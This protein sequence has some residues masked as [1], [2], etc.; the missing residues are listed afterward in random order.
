[1]IFLLLAG[2]TWV[3][4][5]DIKDQL[6]QVDDDGDGFA[7]GVDCND[8]S[9]AVNP[10]APET[11][12][13]GVDQDCAGDDDFDQD[14]DGAAMEVDC[15]DE[16]AAVN[17]G[18]EEV[19]YDGVD[20]DCAGGDEIDVDA[21]GVPYTEDCDDTDPDSYPGAPEVWYDGTDQDC[22]GDADDDQDGDG[23]PFGTDCDD[24]D[25]AV[26]PGAP[27]AWYDG[28]DSDCGGDN[29]YDQDVDGHDALSG[30]G[31]DCDDTDAAV[32]PD[33]LEGIG[34]AVDSDCDGTDDGFRLRALPGR[35]WTGA[36]A[37]VLVAD[38]AEVTLSVVATVVDSG[39]EILYDSAPLFSLVP[40]DAN[41]S[42]SELEGWI[43]NSSDPGA[44]D[45][46]Q[47]SGYQ[48]DGGDSY[49]VLPLDTV[50]GRSLLLAWFDPDAGTRS[51]VT[52]A[53]SLGTSPFDDVSLYLDDG[54]GTHAALGCDATEGVIAWAR[55][56]DPRA[57]TPAA[58]IELGG[59][60]AA[61]CSFDD[62]GQLWAAVGGVLTRIDL[63]EDTDG[64]Y[65]TAV[66]VLD[67]VHAIDLDPAPGGLAGVDGD[68]GA[69][70][71]FDG[72]IATEVPSTVSFSRVDVLPDFS[73][74]VGIGTD[75]GPRWV[76]PDGR[77]T[78]L[79]AP[80]SASDGA[81]VEAAGFRVVV[82][83]GVDGVA[84]GYARLP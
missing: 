40:S 2:C 25:A 30:A 51:T 36:S 8:Q 65:G 22:G 79:T 75:G 45:V 61:A 46:G 33:A 55:L 41:L 5:S 23:S 42:F 59:N 49:G 43:S 16:V 62:G 19:P 70:F 71:V 13:D 15:D 28:V 4:Q 53:G 26:Y 10:D 24:L 73:G 12:Y 39:S 17:P 50:A 47:A 31:D 52:V 60:L 27:D 21:D 78:L 3:S 18:A 14:H 72:T 69:I 77:A 80:F 1:M 81:A 56:D 82:V 83:T 37:P 34:D 63:A 20:N 48:I 35:T 66:P 38:G 68:S 76:E 11:W 32:N 57:T 9:A 44:Y 54:A 58:S 6:A 84:V 29:D 64:W 7:V 74:G 67:G